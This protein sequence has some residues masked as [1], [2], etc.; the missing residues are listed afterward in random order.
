MTSR[1][2]LAA[3]ALVVAAPLGSLAQ[4]KANPPADKKDPQSQIE[5]RSGPGPGQKFLERFVG[6]W[7]VVKTFHP[8]QGEPVAAKGSCRQEMIHGGRFL[9]SEFTFDG[10][11]GKTTGTGIIGFETDAG[12]F[13]SSWVDS[14]STRMSLRRSKDKFEGGEIVLFSRT[15]DEGGREA[16]PSRTVTRLEDDG[17]KIVHRQYSPGPDGTERLVMELLMTRKV[18]PKAG[19]R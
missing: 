5:P 16:R 17:R 12:L 4:P 18:E 3:L 9:R 19:G 13:T 8:R 6:D 11:A 7:D 10:P 15:L 14:R 1:T 2:R